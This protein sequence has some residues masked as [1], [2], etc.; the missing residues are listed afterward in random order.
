[1]WFWRLVGWDCL[2]GVDRLLAIALAYHYFLF[3]NINQ[4]D[5]VLVKK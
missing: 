5:I 4:N 1:M 3:R 2:G